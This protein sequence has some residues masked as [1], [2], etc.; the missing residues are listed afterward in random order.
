MEK[1]IVL[2]NME[3]LLHGGDYN[4]EQWLDRPDILR[5][6]IWLM[7]KAGV[8][9]VTLGVFS[10]SVYEPVEGE[11]HFSWLK[12]IMDELYSHGIYTILATPTGARPVWMDEKY[13]EVMR[14][15]KNDVRNHH[16]L[17]H[18][19][20]MSSQ[21]YREKVNL[22]LK[23]LG[24]TLGSHPGLILWH[25]S[26][27][28]GGECYCDLCQNR[29]HNFLKS[30]YQNNID[31]L[32]TQWWTT[33]WSHRFNKFEQIEPPFFNGEGSIQGLN[34]DWKRFTTWNM[35]DY[36]RFEIE[37]LKN[38]T[39]DI[40]VTT[41]FMRL[42][43][44]LNYNEMA[45]ELDYISWDSYPYWNN[46][47]ETLYKTAAEVAFDHSVMRSFKKNKPFL[48][49]ESVPSQVNWHPF[50]K[51][52]RPGIH[53]LSCLQAVACGSDMVGYF[54]WRKGR[55]SYEQ[56]HG[57]V[58]DHL[59]RS[60]TRVF[61]EVAEVG[62]ILEKIN[63]VKGTL[64]KNQA[65][66]I[67]DWDNRWAIEDMAGL[68]KD[69]KYE[70]TVR[71]HYGI[72]LKNGIDLDVIS[73]E[74]DFTDYNIIVA[75]MLYLLKNGVAEKIKNFVK[76]GGTFIATYLTGYVNEN[77]LCYLGGFPGDGLTEVFGLYTE[78]IDTLYPTD[79]NEISY[80]EEAEVIKSSQETFNV[81][82]YCEIIKPL[83]AKILGTYRKDF[84]AGTPAVTVN[85][86]GN[87]TAYYMGARIEESGMEVLYKSIFKLNHIRSKKIPS[88][89]EYH[90]R[91]GKDNKY[92]FYLNYTS[93]LQ[94]ISGTEWGLNLLTGEYITNEMVL[95]PFDV[96]IIKS[97]PANN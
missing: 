40:P 14:V 5:E 38:I 23:K 71:S 17:R 43:N 20:C 73:S 21:I 89:V 30:K 26:N 3:N 52:K 18:N 47:Y 1:K 42:Y 9:V 34:L 65:A 91:Q 50:N 51:L 90:K 11:F 6:D 57:A 67:F 22:L 56:F 48:L 76:T 84:Y 12:H 36:M 44:G 49:M 94:R 87:G 37:I 25:I 79:S 29:F 86:Y 92:E 35:T 83:Q 69:K 95:Q 70:E 68:S 63:E 54:Q 32:N 59:G 15:S 61:K 85:R 74:E 24:E 78:E 33:F 28:F 75:P 46:D 80:C 97:E 8:N 88:G 41:N 82:D 60:D 64:V 39:P 93:Q 62:S 45:K 31:L 27:E 7:G 4:P 19:H 2:H 16:G 53:K 13:K 72:F 81:R 96:L 10:W 77:T 58:L 66:I 55:G